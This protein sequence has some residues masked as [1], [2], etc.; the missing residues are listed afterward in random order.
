MTGFMNF[1]T[2]TLKK[3][4]NNLASS[5]GS[6]RSVYEA[7]RTDILTS[8]LLADRYISGCVEFALLFFGFFPLFQFVFTL[9]GNLG[10]VLGSLTAY[11]FQF[12]A[13]GYFQSSMYS[14]IKSTL[15]VCFANVFPLSFNN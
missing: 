1:N 6:L 15:T 12:Y 2:I 8:S 9:E 13:V 10:S 11:I 5:F 3:L 7:W 14:F 4:K